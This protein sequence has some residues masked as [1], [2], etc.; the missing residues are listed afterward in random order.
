[1]RR[2]WPGFFLLAVAVLSAASV[3]ADIVFFK[4]GFAAQGKVRREGVTEVDSVTKESYF[5]HKGLWMIDDGP[6][7]VY[8]P[9]RQVSVTEKL[10]QPKDEDIKP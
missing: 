7:R 2:I 8:F 6:R 4:D 3:R 5:L 10:S 1:M 9:P